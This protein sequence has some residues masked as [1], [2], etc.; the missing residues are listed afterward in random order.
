MRLNMKYYFIKRERNAWDTD[1]GFKLYSVCHEHYSEDL[2]RI[3]RGCFA[4]QKC[5]CSHNIVNHLESAEMRDL[6]FLN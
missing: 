6:Q 2:I 5:K 4:F 1:F 3:M